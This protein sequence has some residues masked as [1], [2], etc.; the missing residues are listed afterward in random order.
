MALGRKNPNNNKELF[1]MTVL[2]LKMAVYTN[3]VARLHGQVSRDMWQI[4]YPGV[5]KQE[6]PITHITN[7]VHFQSWLSKELK[8]LYD[9]YLGPRWRDELAD[10]AI[11]DRTERIAS[12]ELWRTHERRRERLVAFSRRRLREQLE[13][14]GASQT[15]IQ[16]AD[17]VLD[18]HVLTIGFARRF[19]TYKRAG[20]IL[21]EPDR[22]DKILNHPR[23]PVQIIFSGKAHPRD[24]PGKELI[25]QIVE[26]ARQ[27]RFRHRIVFLED[28][29]MAVARYLVQ[30]ADVWLNTPRRPREA[31]G[32][33]GMKATANGVLNLSILDGWWDEG[34]A[35][36][37]GWAIGRRESYD[38][39]DYQDQVEAEALYGLLEQEIVPMFYNRGAGGLPRVWINRMKD[40]IQSLC[41]FFNTHRMVGEYAKR[42]YIP[43]SEH[44]INFT[45]DGMQKAIDLASWKSRI[46]SE[47]HQ[48]KVLNVSSP[49]FEDIQVGGE[50]EVKVGIQLGGLRPEDITAELY[51]GSVN[52]HG[53]IVNPETIPLNLI[54]ESVDGE[55]HY[56]ARAAT[57]ECSG[58]FGYTV[59]IL[60]RHPDLVT[61]FMPGIITWA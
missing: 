16:A 29:D 34:Y 49:D 5:P 13:Q 60:P 40:S 45:S 18:P 30:G 22:L 8:E 46:K 3:G 48:V 25:R 61:P 17:E 33:S 19:A 41:Q 6:I 9:R 57:C 38:D 50:F 23:H 2:A 7:G 59:R 21:K 52:S 39:Q 53:D 20:L 11:W 32:T 44:F 4:L 43:V 12:E 1:C 24:D 35:P 42:F 31:S 10:Q 58:L 15:A 14:R 56:Y 27:D 28:Y 47:W 36:E 51:M 54:D 37:I 55:Y 26:L